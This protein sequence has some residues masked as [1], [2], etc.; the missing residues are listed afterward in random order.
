[1]THNTA[2]CKVKKGAKPGAQVLHRSRGEE[3]KVTDA[4]AADHG[5]DGDGGCDAD[6]GADGDGGC[7]A[8]HG[9][10]GDGVRLRC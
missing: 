1:M 2:K 10:D 6:H 9:A 8:D 7:D 4:A 3:C 5:A